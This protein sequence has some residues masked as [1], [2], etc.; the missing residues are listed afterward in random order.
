MAIGTSKNEN[1]VSNFANL[2]LLDP[3]QL[4]LK[5][6]LGYIKIQ[7][8]FAW[9]QNLIE[10][11]TDNP[12][13]RGPGGLQGASF[14][15]S[16]LKDFRSANLKAVTGGVIPSILEPGG[17]PFSTFAEGTITAGVPHPYY[18]LINAPAE[19]I[20]AGFDG[21][22]NFSIQTP[23][24]QS[25]VFTSFSEPYQEEFNKFGK[26]WIPSTTKTSTIV[27]EQKLTPQTTYNIWKLENMSATQADYFNNVEFLGQDPKSG[28]QAVNLQPY[29]QTWPF[30]DAAQIQVYSSSAQVSI[31]RK[32][33][34]A[35][36]YAHELGTQYLVYDGSQDTPTIKKYS[37]NLHNGYAEGGKSVGFSLVFNSVVVQNTNTI[38]Q[39]PSNNPI[40]LDPRLIISWGAL[41]NPNKHT[42]ENKISLYTLEISPNRAPRLYFNISNQQILN[43]NYSPTSNFIELKSLKPI[44]SAQRNSGAKTPNDYKLHVFYSGEFLH[45]GTGDEG[46]NPDTW[47]TINYQ[48]LKFANTSQNNQPTFYHHLD[49][50]SMINISAQY[51]NF[52]FMYGPPLFDPHDDQ[53]LPGLTFNDASA[54]TYNQ[55]SGTMQLGPTDPH[56]DSEELN[57][58]MLENQTS[59]FTIIDNSNT[60][61][62]IFSSPFAYIDARSTDTKYNISFGTARTVAVSDYDFVTQLSYKFTF[63][64]GLGGHVYNKWISPPSYDDPTMSKSY[65]TYFPSHG[66][67]LLDSNGNP[68]DIETILTQAVDTSGFTLTK[69]IDPNTN[70][71]MESTITGLKFINLN[72]SSAGKTILNFMRQNVCV[73]KISAGYGKQLNVFFEGAITDIKPEESLEATKIDVSAEDL[74]IHLFKSPD[75]SIVSRNRVVFPSMKY[76]DVI[77]NLVYYTELKNHFDY[78]GLQPCMKDF[79]V[80]HGL[81]KKAD[82]FLYSKLATFEVKPYEPTQYFNILAQICKLSLQTKITH[83]INNSDPHTCKQ[84][85]IPIIYW[86]ADNQVDGIKM[87][88][89]AN[90]DNVDLLIFRQSSLTG[91]L[92]NDIQN[93]H[94]NILADSAFK[95]S[96]NS[97]NLNTIG[98]Y[99]YLDLDGKPTAVYYYNN[100]ALP[101]DSNFNIIDPDINTSTGYIGYNR[102][103]VFDKLFNEQGN[104]ILTGNWLLPDKTEAQRFINTWMEAVYSQVYENLELHC[105][106]TRPLNDHKFFQIVIENNSQ[107]LITLPEDYYYNSVTYHFDLASNIIRANISGSRKN[108]QNA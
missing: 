88:S 41:D 16:Y 13:H 57:N 96:S 84:Y 97:A 39:S 60:G 42:A 83:S 11:Y 51:M 37:T 17:A 28:V 68:V 101:V 26:P 93:L 24:I 15:N 67:N 14:A 12:Y 92:L 55:A 65:V 74:L 2:P 46:T 49:A 63:P 66:G 80:N 10:D 33:P 107:K 73:I 45:I 81:P 71:I 21:Q 59:T 99:R 106:V 56:P 29:M 5:I 48:K 20:Y 19:E 58:F 32:Y 90:R 36:D 100:Q 31:T 82:S 64:V 44:I 4:N 86:Y 30:T 95:S 87:S 104:S 50:E 98:L 69:R 91:D 105:I 53:N 22:A 18:D 94:G 72:R 89:R 75:T 9:F 3:G 34:M 76:L 23:L 54:N 62:K 78:S 27:A 103:V 108:I 40:L 6:Q 8:R 61:L 47:E 52:S 43:Q 35:K 7:P 102:T 1:Q 38:G 70:T 25:N 85:D 77:K 79:L